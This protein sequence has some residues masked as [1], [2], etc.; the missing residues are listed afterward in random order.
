MKSCKK[1]ILLISLSLHSWM[2]FA[3]LPEKPNFLFILVDDL[4][5]YQDI[6]D[7][8]PQ[9]ETPHIDNLATSGIRFQNAYASCPGCAPSRT[10]M[11]SGK[12]AIYTQVFNNND[13]SSNFRNNFTA[14][15]GNETVFTLPEILKDSGNYYTMAINK[16]FHSQKQNDYDKI[17]ADPCAKNLSWNRM[18]DFEDGG[19]FDVDK[20]AYRYL[21]VFD[22]GAVPNDMETDMVDYRAADSAIL[23]LQQ[24]ADGTANTCDRP[25][26]LALGIKRPHIDRFIPE[27]Y[28]PE[29]FIDQLDSLEF[30]YPYNYPD[31]QYPANGFI[32]PPQPPAGQYSDFDNLPDGGIA[33]IMAEGG[34]FYDSLLAY[35]DTLSVFPEIDPSLTD[36]ERKAIVSRSIEAAYNMTYFAASQFVDAQIGRV[37]DALNDLPDLADSTIVI[38]VSDHGYALG[39]KKHWGKWTLWETVTRVPFIVSGPGLPAN[40]RSSSTVSLLD[41]FPTVLDIAGVNSPTFSDGT[42]Y[43]DGISILPILQQPTLQINRPAVSLYKRGSSTGSCFP[44]TSVRNNRYHM[45]RYR[46]NN[47][48][49]VGISFCDS[50]TLIYENELYDIGINREVDPEEWVNLAGNPEYR[51]LMDYLSQMMP[52]SALSKT[53]HH[54]V[55]LVL[56]P[57][58]CLPTNMNA[59]RI[60]PKLYNENGSII[61]GPALTSYKFVWTHSLGSETFYTRQIN[62]PLG[63]IPTSVF[64]TIDH[65]MFYLHVCDLATDELRAFNLVKVYLNPSS[66]PSGSYIANAS[67]MTVSISDIILEGSFTSLK[68][69][70]NGEYQT[71][72]PVPAPYTFSS[73]GSKT[74]TLTLYYGNGCSVNINETILLGSPPLR[75]QNFVTDGSSI[76]IFPIP[77]D[78]WLTIQ[79]TKPMTQLEVLNLMGQPVASFTPN[80]DA[81]QYKIP[82]HQIL[83]GTYWIKVYLENGFAESRTVVIVR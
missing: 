33:E 80:L 59:V 70:F 22:F 24:V 77:A 29:W 81:Y 74:I 35:L 9:I 16:V 3:Q 49:T 64:D 55:Q 51:P 68:W 42:P 48:G 79:C 46:S 45:I 11:L 66:A 4:N 53:P 41:V 30:P 44:H 2:L 61:S 15:E 6:Y 25:F 75:E 8:H 17:T 56:K 69:D 1:I 10:S 83:P 47:D 58:P 78:D 82:T 63:I 65:M 39:E 50:D 12:D 13:Y 7:G 38:L 20:E 5:D 21:G 67:E 14:A 57:L 76:E 26:F 19:T 32:M 40:K 60:Q 34:E 54:T 62:F 72:S 71:T 28:F 43:L 73:S 37:L 18:L 27:Q 31:N 52:D 36:E 23:F